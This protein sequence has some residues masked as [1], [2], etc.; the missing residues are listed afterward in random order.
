[1]KHIQFGLTALAMAVLTSC[2]GGTAP[3][4]ASG[5]VS[6]QVA[7]S[8]KLQ[9]ELNAVITQLTT[10]VENPGAGLGGIGGITASAVN[11]QPAE[12]DP[13]AACTT[14]T[15]ASLTDED[16]D[17]IS[18]L[19]TYKFDC[20]NV[21]NGE[22]W[23]MSKKGTAVIKDL[24]D[25]VKTENGGGY[26]FDFD[27]NFF[28]AGAFESIYKGFYKLEKLGKKLI[29]TSEYEIVFTETHSGQD[30]AGGSHSN[31]TYTL[32]GVDAEQPWKHGKST[33]NGFYRFIVKGTYPDQ[34]T[35]KDVVLDWDFTFKIDADLEYQR[36]SDSGCVSHYKSGYLEFT[37]ASNNVMRYDYSCNKMTY[38]FNG[39]VIT[40][41][42]K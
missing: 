38:S 18:L 42:T 36:T 26:S 8:A 23:P 24:D 6:L 7:Q 22:G 19:K 17:N 35:G 5:T 12:A 9:T 39:V 27:L 11:V 28:S 37:D 40:S 29:Y 20:N 25:T 14:I 32:E 34:H 16:K 31:Y 30:L 13:F 33:M 21:D 2:G 1:M 41:Q 3:S 10:N 4:S 15:P